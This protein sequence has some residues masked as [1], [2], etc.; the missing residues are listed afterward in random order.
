MALKD[1]LKCG[2]KILKKNYPLCSTKKS[3]NKH[4]CINKIVIV[5]STPYW[6]SCIMLTR[7]QFP[8]NHLLI[9]SSLCHN[10][11][12]STYSYGAS[13]AGDDR[14]IS[15]SSSEASY[16][17]NSLGSRL[18]IWPEPVR[19]PTP[20][21]PPPPPSSLLEVAGPKSTACSVSTSSDERLYGAMMGGLRPPSNPP[22]PRGL[23]E[24]GRQSST[25]SG[26]ATGSHSSYSGSFSSYTGCMDIGHGETDEFGSLTSLPQNPNL[27]FISLINTPVRTIPEH[28]PCVCP[29]REATQMYQVPTSPLQHYDIPRRLLQHQE[30]FLTAANQGQRPECG[31]LGPEGVPADAT[32]KQT[33]PQRSNWGG[34]GAAP[35]ED[36]ATLQLQPAICPDCGGGKVTRFVFLLIF[37]LFVFEGFHIFQLISMEHHTKNLF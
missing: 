24:A 4:H 19:H 1:I 33:V 14:S 6:N 20:V 22:H 28:K 30:Q 31:A 27:N 13:L 37:S 7:S 3:P 35:P 25:D 21:E 34:D 8:F 9:P 12:A 17:D 23:Q 10:W 29:L 32:P 18:A 15:S 11:P 26:I 36:S 5:L 16:S 2:R